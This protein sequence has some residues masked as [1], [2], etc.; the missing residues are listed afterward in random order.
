MAE[1]DALGYGIAIVGE[2]LQDCLVDLV[3]KHRR[4]TVAWVRDNLDGLLLVDFRVLQA[5]PDAFH[6]VREDVCSLRIKR[7]VVTL[8]VQ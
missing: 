3:G 1:R 8:E 5:P 2:F 4:L 7:K 6:G